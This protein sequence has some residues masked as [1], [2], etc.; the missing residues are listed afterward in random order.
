MRHSAQEP[1]RHEFCDLHKL[2]QTELTT[3]KLEQN[4]LCADTVHLT[5]AGFGTIAVADMSA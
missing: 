1:N 2:R 3:R 4:L 5:V